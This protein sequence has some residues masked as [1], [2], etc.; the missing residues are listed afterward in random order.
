VEKPK[1]KRQL[2]KEATREHIIVTAMS[3]YAEHGFAVPV[4]VI[5]EAAG[6]AHGS[7]FLHFPTKEDLL[8]CVLERF[9]RRIAERMHE[10]A[11]ARDD[12]SALLGEFLAIIEEYEPF[13]KRLVTEI[14]ALPPN[15]RNMLVALRSAN[16]R[17]FETAMERGIA[18]GRIKPLPLHMMFN[19]WMGLVYYYLQNGNL[20]A[21]GK[22]VIK[23]HKDELVSFYMSLITK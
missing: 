12:I 17:H 4:G 9:F 15:T 20:F 11:L 19:T 3:V 10:L 22:S 23:T 1:G 13:Y 16:A 2:Q 18:Q 21:P 14:H 7:V 6:L 5:A 8:Y